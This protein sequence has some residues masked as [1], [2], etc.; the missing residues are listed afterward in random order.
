MQERYYS[1]DYKYFQEH[2]PNK[3]RLADS[4]DEIAYLDIETTGLRHMIGDKFKITSIVLFDG[5]SIKYYINGFN[6]EQ[7]KEDIR[8]YQA[9]V[10]F[11]GNR[12]DL[13]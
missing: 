4:I 9:V 11:N 7:F 2:L 13:P 6:L 10:T 3:L 1:K 5:Y 8:S 12:F